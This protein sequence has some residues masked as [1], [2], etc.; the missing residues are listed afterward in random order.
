MK[1]GCG[2]VTF[3]FSTFAPEKYGDKV[4][5]W[6]GGYFQWETNGRRKWTS[7]RSR[8]QAPARQCFLAASRT[9]LSGASSA[10][11]SARRSFSLKSGLRRASRRIVLGAQLM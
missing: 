8:S 6:N 5:D 1:R 10:A 9:A 3:H 2:L 4:L 11:N 7:A